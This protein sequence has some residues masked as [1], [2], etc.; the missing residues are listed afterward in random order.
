MLRTILA[1]ALIITLLS[2]CAPAPVPPTITPIPSTPTSGSS[3]TEEATI[4]QRANPARTG[5]Y[6]FPA[7]RTKPKVKWRKQLDSS[8]TFG[9]PLVAENVLYT[10]GSDGEIYALNAQT[11]DLL[12]SGGDFEATETATAIAGDVLIG[13]GQNNTVKALN[14]SDGAILWTFHAGTFVFAPPVIVGNVV[15]IA[16]YEKLYALSLDTGKQA[17]AAPLGSQMNFV[18]TPA[19]EGDSVYIN[20]GPLLV[21]LDRSSGAE[22]WR[23]ET[24][25]QF[26]WLALGHG[27]VYVGNGDGYFYAYDQASGKERWK[28]K[29]NFGRDEVWAAPA[30][31]GDIVYTGS[32]DQYVYALNAE[33][34]EKV[35]SYK[36]SGDAVGDPIVSDGLVYLSDSNHLLPPGARHLL[37]LDAATGEPV[38]DYEISSTLLTTPAL[39]QGVIFTTIA[40]EV[41]AL[42]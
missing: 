41:I 25:M 26:F 4:L 10:G 22:R 15:Y 1:I 24:P 29:S 23:V 37:A 35:W 18:G 34:G 31:A 33:T 13:G 30:I 27:L 5:L 20:V 3:P 8:L 11:G 39:S 7:I 42:Q 9:T 36:T 6:N 28:F 2:G 21:A 14:R 38:W 16:T 19:V 17:W 40:G 32:R 12:W